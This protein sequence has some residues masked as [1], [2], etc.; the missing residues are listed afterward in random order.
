VA[1]EVRRL[2]GRVVPRRNPAI[3]AGDPFVGTS[4]ERMAVRMPVRMVPAPIRDH[5]RA[6]L[7]ARRERGAD[8]LRRPRSRGPARDGHHPEHG[9]GRPWG[10]LGAPSSAPPGAPSG[11]PGGPVHRDRGAARAGAGQG[12]AASAAQRQTA[13]GA[14]AGARPDARATYMEPYTPDLAGREDERLRSR[15]APTV[16]DQMPPPGPPGAADAV[17]RAAGRLARCRTRRADGRRR[18]TL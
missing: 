12:M 6:P 3:R 10:R 13:L 4:P 8:C 5:V 7:A 2:W 9:S 11:A 1:A 17:R 18:E 16:D 14:L 15:H